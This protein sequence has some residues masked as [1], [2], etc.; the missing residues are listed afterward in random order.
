[1]RKGRTACPGAA[2]ILALALALVQCAEPADA[3]DAARCDAFGAAPV[4]VTGTIGVAPRPGVG[5][6]AGAA[7][8]LR[9]YELRLA[10]DAPLC[11][12]DAATGSAS[13]AA[14]VGVAEL[15]IVYGDRYRFRRVWLGRHVSV[16]GTMIV[17]AARRSAPLAL[18]ARETH[19]LASRAPAARGRLG[20]RATARDT[21]SR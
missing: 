9:R 10:L 12:G 11:V 3:A 5:E 8:G 13:A 6:D 18:E 16:T 17:P 2:G 1:V 21:A 19:I 4:I 14:A 7:P 20:D 15:P